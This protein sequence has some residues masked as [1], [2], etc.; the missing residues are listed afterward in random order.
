MGISLLI[1]KSRLFSILTITKNAIRDILV[2]LNVY[3]YMCMC[4]MDTQ[5]FLLA[6]VLEADLLDERI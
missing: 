5:K 3:I 4:V 2:H 6:R 1:T